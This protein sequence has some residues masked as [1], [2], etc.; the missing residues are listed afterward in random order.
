MVRAFD[1][2][3]FVGCCTLSC[4][5][6]P[7]RLIPSQ[8]RRHCA[9]RILLS[10]LSLDQGDSHSY[11]FL[12]AHAAL[13]DFSSSPNTT[14]TKAVAKL[15]QYL[16]FDHPLS[17]FLLPPQRSPH[18]D[19]SL[20][21]SL[22]STLFFDRPTTL[23]GDGCEWCAHRDSGSV[24]RNGQSGWWDL[25]RVLHRHPGAGLVLH[26]QREIIAVFRLLFSWPE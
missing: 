13:Q 19:L 7:A 6:H 24:S 10:Q 16:P 20:A 8:R 14:V 15:R 11:K 12:R 9:H 18:H 2:Q 3:P 1:T 26:S 21:F 22:I 25:W 5:C 23:E 4:Y 17:S